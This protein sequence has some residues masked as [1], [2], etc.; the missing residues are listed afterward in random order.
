[1]K[2]FH[3]TPRA[4]ETDPC[5]SER[6]CHVNNKMLGMSDERLVTLFRRRHPTEIFL[7]L[8]LMLIAT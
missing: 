5:M 1:V 4:G 2:P 3:D 8:V 7:T 6:N